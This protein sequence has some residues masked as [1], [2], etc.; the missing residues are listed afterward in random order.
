[1][2]TTAAAGQLCT[3]TNPPQSHLSIGVKLF[4]S[5]EPLL[6]LASDLA[7][8]I[9]KVLL[10]KKGRLDDPVDINQATIN[11]QLQFAK[12]NDGKILLKSLMYQL[13][14]SDLK[15]IEAWNI[16]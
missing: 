11:L 3:F 2:T 10:R 15:K 4:K 8:L 16:A 13:F 12:N 6:Q 9:E 14:S 5:T 1:L 7:D